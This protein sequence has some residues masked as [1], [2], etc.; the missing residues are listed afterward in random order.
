M[1]LGPVLSAIQFLTR[2]PV[3]DPGWEEGRLRAALAFFP[4]AG[5][6]VGLIGAGVWWGAVQVLPAAVAAGLALA[7]MLL[8]T[9]AMHEDGLGDVADGLGG[10]ATAERALEIMRDSRIGSY[11]LLAVGL[12]VGLRWAALAALSAADGA[13]A[14]VIA[15][16][17]ARAAMVPA[18]CIAAP[19]RPDGLGRMLGQ[20]ADGRGVGLALGLGLA[21]ALAGGW[22]GLGALVAALVVMGLVVRIMRRR[23]G[24]MTGDGYGAIA[25]LAETAAMLVFAAAWGGT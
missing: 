11:A 3:P 9:G 5:A 12:A 8:A 16:T 10:G 18:S 17:A 4:V 1:R 24:G 25:S 7:A 15:A 23:V 14:L 20:G 19:A 22:A 13:L 2:L 21:A 6:L